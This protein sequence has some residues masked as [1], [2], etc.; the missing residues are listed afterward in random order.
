MTGNVAMRNKIKNAHR[1]LM[2]QMCEKTVCE[3]GI[4]ALDHI[5]LLLAV[6]ESKFASVFVEVIN[7]H[8][9]KYAKKMYKIGYCDSHYGRKVQEVNVGVGGKKNI[10]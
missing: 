6:F 10:C 5:G 2:E 9:S 4:R 7:E 1:H 8:K 3:N